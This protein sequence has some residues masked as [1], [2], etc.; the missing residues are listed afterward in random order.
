MLA[1]AGY[2]LK[3]SDDRGVL[4]T[5]KRDNRAPKTDKEELNG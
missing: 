5:V 3:C 1:L 2:G 4:L